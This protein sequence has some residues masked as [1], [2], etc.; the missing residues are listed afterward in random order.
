MSN[1]ED[2]V[3]IAEK[4]RRNFFQLDLRYTEAET[5]MLIAEEDFKKFHKLGG[6]NNQ[7]RAQKANIKV[8]VLKVYMV[9][10]QAIKEASINKLSLIL[11]TY[12]QI[13]EV[14][15]PTHYGIV[16]EYDYEEEE[17][18]EFLEDIEEEL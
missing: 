11:D 13:L 2:N 3:N 1:N 6:V 9:N 10:I 5:Q 16:D 8:R 15:D 7:K 12:N 18:Q 4:I 14:L 17:E